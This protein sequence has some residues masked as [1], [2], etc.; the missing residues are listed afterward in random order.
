MLAYIYAFLKLESLKVLSSNKLPFYF[1][2]L[3]IILV[4]H[5]ISKDT[6]IYFWYLINIL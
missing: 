4:T 6:K 1:E 2:V 5:N 3:S